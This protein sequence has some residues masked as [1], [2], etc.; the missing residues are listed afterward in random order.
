M[1]RLGG[2]GVYMQIKE[3]VRWTW[4]TPLYHSA[5]APSGNGLGATLPL[6]YCL[7]LIARA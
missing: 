2:L 1:L 4:V 6:G 7:S 5:S 3:A